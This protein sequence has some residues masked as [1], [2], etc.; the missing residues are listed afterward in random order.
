MKDLNSKKCSPEVIEYFNKMFD[1]KEG[2]ELPEYLK[3]Q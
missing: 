1:P 3:V 2:I